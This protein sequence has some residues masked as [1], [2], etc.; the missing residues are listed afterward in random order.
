M[1]RASM[2][3]MI[4]ALLFCTS[5]ISGIAGPFDQLKNLKIDPK[6]VMQPKQSA[7]EFQFTNFKLNPEAS[8]ASRVWSV[9]LRI[10][11]SISTNAY[12]VKTV[13]QNRRG[14]TLFSGDDIALPAGNAGKTY[15]LMRPFQKDSNV[16]A[17]VFHVYNQADN[18]I[19]AS[20]A[21]PLAAISSYGIRGAT[22]SA[23]PAAP[24][25]AA[26]S[27]V[28]I[29]TSIDYSFIFGKIEPG[30]YDHRFQI[31]NKSSFPLKI[32]EISAKAKFLVGIDYDI[33]VYCLSQEIQPGQSVSC[34]FRYSPD[35][36]T[37][38]LMDF[39]VKLN[40]NI[41]NEEL[42]FDSPIRGI[43]RVPLIKLEKEKEGSGGYGNGSGTAE[44]IIRGSYVKPGGVVTMKAF[45]SVDSDRF[46]VVFTG[47][48]EDD[49]IHAAVEVVGTHYLKTP[50]KFCFHLMEITTCDDLSCG[51]VGVLLYR[52]IFNI[53][54]WVGGAGNANFFLLQK[55]CK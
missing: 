5:P 28:K 23:K 54:E 31:Q 47:R 40:G 48:Q 35:C 11:Q 19:V 17:V 21:Y 49:G 52:N 10:S 32:N 29:D 9:D 27:S 8:D 46:P 53:S 50:D 2:S 1:K 6:A 14:D 42:K 30:V 37:L 12:L 38:N 24:Q 25:R 7:V 3:I 36:P 15:Q 22:T 33:K 4:F 34:G 51:G 41:Y 44:I 45:A 20:Q 39:Q 43:D 16:S 55:Y 26:D 13:F 18:K